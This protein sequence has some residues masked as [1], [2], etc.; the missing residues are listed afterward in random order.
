MPFC[1]MWAILRFV[2]VLAHRQLFRS[3]TQANPCTLSEHI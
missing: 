1:K 3:E 2:D